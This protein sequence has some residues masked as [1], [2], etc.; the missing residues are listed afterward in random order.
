MTLDGKGRAK[1][2][3]FIERGVVGADQRVE[4]HAYVQAPEK[5]RFPFVRTAC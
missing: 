4:I 3:S 2:H 1:T 5:R